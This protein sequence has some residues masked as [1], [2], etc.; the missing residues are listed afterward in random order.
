[1]MLYQIDSFIQLLYPKNP[2][3]WDTYMGIAGKTA[4]WLENNMRPGFA[5]YLRKDV[6][7]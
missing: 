4:E 3:Y 1:M 7:R 6:R 5:N 2:E